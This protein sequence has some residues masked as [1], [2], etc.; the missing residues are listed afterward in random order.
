ME[1][2]QIHLTN[3]NWLETI[4]KFIIWNTV[5]PHIKVDKTDQH[6]SE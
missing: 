5:C 6:E 2:E 1:H 3:Y 4:C